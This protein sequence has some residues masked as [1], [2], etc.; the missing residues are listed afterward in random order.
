MNIITKI[1]SY[2]HQGRGLS[3][4]NNKVIFIPKSLKDEELEVKIVEE[5]HNYIIG[6]IVNIIKPSP[7]RITPIC[8]F[9]DKCGGCNY[10]HTS[11][12]EELNIKKE[13]LINIFK[14]YS[15]KYINPIIINSPK[16]NN[17]RNK[18]ELKINNYNWGYY[19]EKTHNFINIDNC[20][21]AKNSINKIIES[22]DSLKIK[23]GE[24]II[25]SNYNDEIIIKITTQNKYQIDTETLTKNNKIVGIIV[26]DKLIYGED[27]YIELVNK[28]LFKVNINSFFQ[29]NI[30][31]LKEV[32]NILEKERYQNVV[33]LYCGV[34]TLGIATNKEKLYGIEI[35]PEAIKD[36]ITN[37]KMN[38]QNNHYLLGDSTNI[39]KIKDNIDCIIVDPPRSGLNTKTLNSLL[40]YQ[41]QNIFYMSCN[42]LTLA[43]DINL[44][45]NDYHLKQIYLL[46]MF[47]RTK[48]VECVSVLS[49][50]SQ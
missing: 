30:D 33:D 46:D 19:N 12:E 1:E 20:L 26:N 10:L 28:Y 17:Y 35:V 45:K 24:I 50:K 7:K 49:R 4:Y 42:P 22:K 37:S 16:E 15:N 6:E 39:T 40:D 21:L 31:I 29:I 18:I 27:N 25:R 43:R 13:I 47:P 23:N 41:P 11:H 34:G 36:A 38:K 44:L 9:Y 14:R 3:H 48:H 5:K 2:D 32:F 8:K